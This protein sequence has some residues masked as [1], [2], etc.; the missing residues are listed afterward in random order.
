[1][2][3]NSANVQNTGRR[4]LLWVVFL[5]SA[6]ANAVASS[7]GAPLFISIPL[8]VLALASAVTLIVQHFRRAR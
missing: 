2:T 4:S 5:V 3:Q 7:L 6:V 8:G 1:M